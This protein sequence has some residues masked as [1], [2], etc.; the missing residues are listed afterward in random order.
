[1]MAMKATWTLMVERV[2]FKFLEAPLS[3]AQT[4][5][6]FVDGLHRGAQTPCEQEATCAAGALA[7]GEIL[8]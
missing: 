2:T 4:G 7:P 3:A 5:K 6:L 8:N 1:M